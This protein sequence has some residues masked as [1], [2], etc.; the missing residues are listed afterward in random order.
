MRGERKI[1]KLV[2]KFTGIPACRGEDFMFMVDGETNSGLIFW[3]DGETA[4]LNQTWSYRLMEDYG[5]KLT[6]ENIFTMSI[7]HEMGHAMTVGNFEVEDWNIEYALKEKI[8]EEMHMSKRTA[9]RIHKKF[10]EGT[11]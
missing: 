8:G 9:Q 10:L 7:L 3:S 5:F 6:N 11:N 2:A 1:S 4:A